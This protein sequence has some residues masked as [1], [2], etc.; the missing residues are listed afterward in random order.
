M[1]TSRNNEASITGPEGYVTLY[2]LRWL[3]EQLKDAEGDHKITVKAERG[4]HQLDPGSTRLSA[5]VPERKYPLRVMKDQ[6]QA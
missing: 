5:Q 2:D 3:V 6:P 4:G 1:T